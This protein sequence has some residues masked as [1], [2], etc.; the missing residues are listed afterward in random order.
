MPLMIEGKQY[1]NIKE[2][3]EII[4]VSEGRIRQ[5]IF[6]ERLPS[7]QIGKRLRMLPLEAVKTFAE[8]TRPSGIHRDKTK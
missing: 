7:I 3:A 4:G 8:S 2:A 5:F 6:L 1:V